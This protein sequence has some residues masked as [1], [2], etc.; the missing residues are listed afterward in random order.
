MKIQEST[1][2]LAAGLCGLL[3]FYYAAGAVFSTFDVIFKVALSFG[4]GALAL[5]FYE[6]PWD[7]TVAR[8]ESALAQPNKLFGIAQFAFSHLKDGCQRGHTL[9]AT[10]FTEIQDFFYK[11][12]VIN[13]ADSDNAASEH[14]AMTQDNT[15]SPATKAPVEPTV[16]IPLSQQ[17]LTFVQQ[18][19]QTIG[20]PTGRFL[21]ELFKPAR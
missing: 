3:A 19:K 8:F 21:S 7:T 11:E 15:G 20:L 9:M 6:Q 18:A 13:P 10:A 14:D 2:K 17:T 4:S 1:V 12:D 16:H 5:A